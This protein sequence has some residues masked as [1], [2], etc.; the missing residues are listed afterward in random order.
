[1]PAEGDTL[2]LISPLSLS[3]NTDVL[4]LCMRERERA[5]AVD[6]PVSALLPAAIECVRALRAC[7]CVCLAQSYSCSACVS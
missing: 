3:V 5:R 4:T 7:V 6:L 1:M 2:G